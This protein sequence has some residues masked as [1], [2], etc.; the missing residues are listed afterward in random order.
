MNMCN[1]KHEVKI[2]KLVV[3]VVS[4]KSVFLIALLSVEF[5]FSII[6]MNIKFTIKVLRCLKM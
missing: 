4:Y 6:V 3:V 5:F 2:C 1:E